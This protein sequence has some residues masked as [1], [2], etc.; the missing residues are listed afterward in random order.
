MAG[1]DLSSLAVRVRQLQGMLGGNRIV[2]GVVDSTGAKLEGEGFTSARTGAGD[3]TITFDL[4]FS[5]LPAV[6]VSAQSAANRV[7]AQV[8][9]P[10]NSTIRVIT[11]VDAA[12]ANSDQVF[13][14]IAIGPL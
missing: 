4:P 7:G 12:G 5:D 14:F 2:R 3:Y 8:A 9:S 1:F 6:T 11:H 13:H 10:T